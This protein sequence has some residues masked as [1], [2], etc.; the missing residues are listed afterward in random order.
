MITN[1]LAYIDGRGS[2][3]SASE[4]AFQLAIRH[5]VHVEGLHVRV[6]ARDFMTN[7]PIY[8][9]AESLENFIATFDREAKNLEKRA[10][11]AFGQARERHGIIEQE[12]T[13]PVKS[14]TAHCTVISGRASDIVC[15]RARVA[16]LCVIGR[17][18][19]GKDVATTPVIEAALFNSGRPVLVAPPQPTKSVGGNIVIAWNR[20]AAAARALNTAMP[21]FD[22]ADSIR[23]VYADTGAKAGPSA[24]EAA[25]YIERHGFNVEAET[26]QPHANGPGSTLLWA[27]QNADLLVMGA[28]SHSRLREVVLGG[29][30]RHVLENATIPVFMVH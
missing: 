23:I 24:D 9:G 19:Y 15:E 25:A 17:A 21:L 13:T 3:E 7:A 4:A 18:G 26:R 27:A 1:I 5:E 22:K 14:P 16:D 11:D 10:T 8:S 6:D 29:V 2:D 20:S 28:Y 30:T 12:A